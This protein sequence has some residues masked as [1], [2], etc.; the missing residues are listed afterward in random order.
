M[1]VSDG[2]QR[3]TFISYGWVF[4]SSKQDIYAE[5]AGPGMGEPTSHRA[6]AWGMLSGVTFLSHLHKYTNFQDSYDKIQ[7][8]I[9]FLS[10]N[11]GLVTR[12]HQRMQ[13]DK[14][15]PNATLAP[16]WDLTEQIY[17][18]YSTLNPTKLDY[19]WEKGHQDRDL[20]A[21]LSTTAR[22]NIRADTLAGEYMQISPESRTFVP[23]YPAARC[24]FDLPSGTVTSHYTS[25]IRTAMAESTFFQYME[26]RHGWSPSIAQQIDWQSFKQAARTY[27]S[28][29]THLL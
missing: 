8:P 14:P 12:I 11:K 6:E 27:T 19:S 13:Y 24:C 9:T 16:D 2:S 3:G 20:N 23:L 29:D 15:Y 18:T 28:S 25:A 21:Q 7:I 22:F 17:A 1:V 26:K 5:H 10:D 4:G